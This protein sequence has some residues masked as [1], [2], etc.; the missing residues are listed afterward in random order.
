M[1]INS[2]I[3]I[4]LKIEVIK[5]IA[6]VISKYTDIQNAKIFGSRAMGN[7]KKYSDIDIAIYNTDLDTTIQIKNDLEELDIIYF[8]DVINYSMISNKD[9]KKNIDE[10][11]FCIKNIL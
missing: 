2:E 4:G 9:L 7:Y 10:S 5:E 3:K 8:C 6:N 11:G 1:Q